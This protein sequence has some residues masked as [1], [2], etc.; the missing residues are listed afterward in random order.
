LMD[1]EVQSGGVPELVRRRLAADFSALPADLPWEAA[2]VER[3][4]LLADRLAGA[5]PARWADDVRQR[6]LAIAEGGGWVHGVRLD[7]E[8][9]FGIRLAPCGPASM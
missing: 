4:R 5:A 6:K 7:L 2:E 9:Q 3:M 8:E 1:A